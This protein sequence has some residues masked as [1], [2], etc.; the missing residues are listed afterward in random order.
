[1]DGAPFR[2]VRRRYSRS[3]GYS[4]LDLRQDS[5]PCN[6]RTDRPI[7]VVVVHTSSRDFRLI[8]RS[9]LFRPQL[10]VFQSHFLSSSLRFSLSPSF[11]LSAFSFS[12]PLL[13][14]F[15]LSP[16]FSPSFSFSFP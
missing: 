11:P 12:P 7:A 2:A 13:L 5:A 1:M 4:G 9:C 15:L 6:F 14:P 10:R 16:P 3:V 8:F